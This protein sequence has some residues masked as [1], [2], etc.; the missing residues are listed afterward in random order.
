MY[1]EYNWAQNQIVAGGG[2]EPTRLTDGTCQGPLTEKTDGGR[3]GGEMKRDA[4][5]KQKAQQPG[6]ENTVRWVSETGRPRAQYQ[7]CRLWSIRN[8]S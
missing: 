4:E 7:N 1:F 2:M 5:F 6:S 3:G 8:D